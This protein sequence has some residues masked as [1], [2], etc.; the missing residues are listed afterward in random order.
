MVEIEIVEKV[1]TPY[2]C[3]F[4]KI[5]FENGIVNNNTLDHPYYVANKGWCSYMPQW[6]IKK[7]GLPTLQL[8]IGDVCLYL[9]SQEQIE[10]I[11]V[12]NIKIYSEQQKTYNLTKVNKNHNFFANRILVHNKFVEKYV[13]F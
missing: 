4:M 3:D 2:N 8:S 5:E 10:M 7:Y 9:N 12:M 13:I 1:D 11:K 6:T